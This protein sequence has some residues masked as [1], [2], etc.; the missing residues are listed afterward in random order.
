[1]RATLA[2]YCPDGWVESYTVRDYTRYYLLTDDGEG[3][4]GWVD[5]DAR[6]AANKNLLNAEFHVWLFD[7]L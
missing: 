3:W 6:S 2:V 7:V 5:D 1:M 4:V